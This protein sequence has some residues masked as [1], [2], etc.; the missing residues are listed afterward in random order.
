MKMIPPENRGG[1]YS[2]FL[3]LPAIPTGTGGRATTTKNCRIDRTGFHYFYRL[4]KITVSRYSLKL[5]LG[6]P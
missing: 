1:V 5:N 2:A 4:V 6:T 3:P